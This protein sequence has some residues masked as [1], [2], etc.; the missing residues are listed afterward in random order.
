M[1]SRHATQHQPIL[2]QRHHRLERIQYRPTNETTAF[3]QPSSSSVT[4]NRVN[5]V[6]P[7]SID[8]TLTANGTVVIVKPNGVFFGPTST[9]DVAGLVATT[10]N[11]ADSDFMQG[12]L[13]FSKPGNP[14]AAVVNQGTITASDA[15]L[16]GLVAPS[17]ENDG[18]INAKLGRATLASGDTF[19]LDL[20][21]DKLI[22]VAVTS[23]Q[24][25]QQVVANT[26]VIQADGGTVTMTAA[27]ASVMS[28]TVFDRQ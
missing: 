26:G 28:L 9:V 20:A 16:V 6:N 24:L 14:N 18:V 27:A 23:D 4:L 7:S 25:P 5:D 13:K 12:K 22:S 1:S 21:G 8:G 3:H 2:Q 11:I 19:T 17:V 15:G 10:A